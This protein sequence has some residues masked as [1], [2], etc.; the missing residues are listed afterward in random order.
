MRLVTELRRTACQFGIARA[1]NL[2]QYRGHLIPLLLEE[3][4]YETLSWPLANLQMISFKPF[5][6]GLDALLKMWG[7]AYKKAT[8]RKKR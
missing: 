8:R 4:D 3:C 7:I 5:E 1:L 6:R 2:P